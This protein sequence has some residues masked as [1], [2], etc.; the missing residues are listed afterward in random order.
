MRAKGLDLA[1]AMFKQPKE[2]EGVVV[3]DTVDVHYRIIEGAK[4]RIQVFG[5]V[6]IAI[7]GGVGANRMMTVRR[8]VAN[9]GVER[10][11]PMNSPRIDKVEVKRHGHTRRAKLYFLRDRIGKARRL[12]D[13]RRGLKNATSVK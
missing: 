7:K 6:V 9:E 2:V 13:Q 1:E 11:F 4:E 8:I 10:I 5:G 12:K 3:G